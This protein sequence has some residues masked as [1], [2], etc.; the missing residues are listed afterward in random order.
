M[1]LI[2]TLIA[3]LLFNAE[4]IAMTFRHNQEINTTNVPQ[5]VVNPLYLKILKPT[6]DTEIKIA[7][8]YK[9]K[10]NII[11]RELSFIPKKKWMKWS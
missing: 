5:V 1:R 10:E 3:I 8:L 4:A 7:I 11:R 2:L 6:S 9:M